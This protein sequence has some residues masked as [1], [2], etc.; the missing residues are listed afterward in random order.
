[1]Q[2]PRSNHPPAM[3]HT[4]REK[5]P[6]RVSQR[7]LSALRLAVLVWLPMSS[8]DAIEVK[9]TIKKDPP[10]EV[11]LA[12]IVIEGDAPGPAREQ[13]QLMQKFRETLGSRPDSAVAEHRLA[14][15]PLKMTTPLGRLCAEPPPA[16]LESGLGGTITLA[17]PCAVF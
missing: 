5:R 16:H 14:N 9:A 17:A 8:A 10:A 7:F 1:M 12:P 13:D 11:P 4:D 6:A 15:G 3:A 2:R